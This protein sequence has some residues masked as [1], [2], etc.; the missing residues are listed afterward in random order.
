VP[1]KRTVQ[2]EID[3]L[4]SLEQGEVASQTSLAGRISVSVGLL[5]ALLRRAAKKGYVKI[6][7]APY[8]RYGYYL[9]PKG[10]AEKGRLVA[11]YLETSLDFFRRARLEYIEVF[12]QAQAAGRRRAVLVGGGDLAEIAL[13]AARETEFE[14]VGMFDEGTNA[15]R[16]HGLPVFRD[17]GACKDIDTF[18]ITDTSRPQQ[19]FERLLG[20]W[21]EVQIF[22]PPLLRITR[23]ASA[24]ATSAGVEQ[25]ETT[26]QDQAAVD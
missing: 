1:D 22:A 2:T 10:F 21:E 5:N 19:V 15:E 11:K 18:V 6:R 14:V 8:R 7:K 9:T 12:A 25:A 4:S 17:W 13:I 20:Q 26:S 24:F 23:Q 3:L 16:M